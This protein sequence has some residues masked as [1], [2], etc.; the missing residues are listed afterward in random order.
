MARETTYAQANAVQ[1][2]LRRFAGSPPGAWLFARA[3]H[4]LDRPVFRLTRG[5]HTIGNLVT[6]LPVLMLTTTGAR[7]G[8]PRTVPVLGI[9]TADGLAV[10]ASNFGQQHHPAWYHNLR[11]DP[12]ATV[13]VHGETRA[14]RAVLTEGEQRQRI[15][16]EALRWYPGWTF[17]ERHAS[18]RQIG[19]FL[20]KPG[21][22]GGVDATAASPTGAAPE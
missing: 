16:E 6:G 7:S 13:V 4:R 21:H 10:L 9:P 12:E 8:L 19:V 18:H 11:A 20:L 14:V 2:G 15:W 3:A 1:K 17:Y 22:D 5:R